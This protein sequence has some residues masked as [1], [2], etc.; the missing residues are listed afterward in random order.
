MTK[1]DLSCNE[2]IENYSDMV[3][4]IAISQVG[5]KND[6]DDIYQEVFL[7]LIRHISSLKSE[8]H[9]KYWLIRTTINKC[10]NHLS[11]FWRNNITETDLNSFTNNNTEVD[12]V[13]YLVLALKPKFK[14]VV[15]LHYYEGYKIDEIALILKSRPGT[16]KSRLYKARNILKKQIAKG[17]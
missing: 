9:V 3:Y 17:D 1:I 11:S 7:Q 15:Y 12:D 2:I 4:R 14:S 8:K 10:K 16:I 5:N 13:Y 6:A